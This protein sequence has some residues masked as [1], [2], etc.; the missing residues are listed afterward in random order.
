MTQKIEGTQTQC[1]QALKT[2]HLTL[3]EDGYNALHSLSDKSG[4]SEGGVVE[5]GIL[6]LEWIQECEGRDQG[7]VAYLINGANGR[8]YS[9]PDGLKKLIHA[10]I[11]ND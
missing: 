3:T 2:I 9:M 1:S 7:E 8:G 5:C 4:H 6:L 11:N 10:V